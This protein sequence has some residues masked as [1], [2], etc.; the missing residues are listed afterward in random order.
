[1]SYCSR[2]YSYYL[3]AMTVC[4]S[5]IPLCSSSKAKSL[6][7]SRR[8]N[9]M[10]MP[11]AMSSMWRRSRP[12]QLDL[13]QLRAS[14]EHSRTLSHFLARKTDRSPSRENK[15]VFQRRAERWGREL[16]KLHRRSR[17]RQM[18][19]C[20]YEIKMLWKWCNQSIS[21]S[22]FTAR[23]FRVRRSWRCKREEIQCL[24]PNCLA[25]A[26]AFQTFSRSAYVAVPVLLFQ[27]DVVFPWHREL[28]IESAALLSVD[29]FSWTLG[30]RTVQGKILWCFVAILL[31]S[32]KR[33]RQQK[34]DCHGRNCACR[35]QKII[36][37]Y[38]VLKFIEDH[39]TLGTLM[40]RQTSL[41]LFVCERWSNNFRIQQLFFLSH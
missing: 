11:L 15:S 18:E 26:A 10:S 30:Q 13:R 3:H 8:S 7:T 28:E 40:N 12:I 5:P 29:R 41:I 24:F 38:R 19:T 35:L 36:N 22:T 39:Q 17:G 20:R 16:R 6:E 9:S 37:K 14:P 27:V 1:M 32:C 4:M 23:Y 21:G 2:S 34:L 33:H 31:E 25:G